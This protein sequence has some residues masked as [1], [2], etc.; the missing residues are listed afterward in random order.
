MAYYT[1]QRNKVDLEDLRLAYKQANEPKAGA[2][3]VNVTDE[4]NPP[5]YFTLSEHPK[6]M[7][8]A[9]FIPDDDKEALV[10]FPFKDF[11]PLVSS[12]D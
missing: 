6:H 5:R 1:R 9:Y 4:R 10:A 12:L 3:G 2:W 7:G 11:W 8:T